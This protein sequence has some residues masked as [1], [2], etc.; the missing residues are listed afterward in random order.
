MIIRNILSLA[1]QPFNLTLTLALSLIGRGKMG[2][3]TGNM[4][5][6]I[7]RAHGLHFWG[8]EDLT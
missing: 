3:Q 4:V 8:K 2:V 1:R 7:N 5:Y 6:T